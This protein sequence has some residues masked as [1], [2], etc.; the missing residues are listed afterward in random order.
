M[1]EG[2]GHILSCRQGG[3]FHVRI[4]V[5]NTSVEVIS[6]ILRLVG[7]GAVHYDSRSGNGRGI[8]RWVLGRKKEMLD[9]A[10][11]ISP[12]LADKSGRLEDALVEIEEASHAR[13]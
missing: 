1:I 9:L 10:P 13:T 4:G 6:T 3:A 5:A 12:Y 11:Q 2:E 8:W 7:A